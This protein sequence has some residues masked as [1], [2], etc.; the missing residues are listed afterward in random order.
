MNTLVSS[1]TFWSFVACVF[2]SISTAAHAGD[3]PQWRY[4]AARS[5]TSPDELPTKLHLQWTRQLPP[6]RPAWPQNQPALRFDVSYSPVAAGKMLFVPSMVTDT[7]TAYDTETGA[8]RWRFYT[9]G[10]VRFAPIVDKGRLYAASD[11]GYLYCLDAEKGTQ[12]W[13]FRA[14]PIERNVLGNERLISTWPVRGGPVLHDGTVYLTAG[15]WPFMG[16]FVYA[17]SAE[18]GQPTWTNSTLGSKYQ[19][20]PHGAPSFGGL[21]PRGHLAVTQAGLV[22]PGGRTSP[23]TFDLKTGQL[24]SFSFGDKGGGRTEHGPV[25]IRAGSRTFTPGADQITASDGWFADVQ[26]NVWT[27]LAADDKLF[28]VTTTG[29]VYCFGGKETAEPKKYNRDLPDAKIAG[30]GYCVFFGLG[31]GDE[32]ADMLANSRFYVIVIDPDANKID[33]FRRR[34]TEAGFYGVRVSAH[35]G[36]PA[37]DPVGHPLPPYL[38]KRV[39]VADRDAA[40]VDQGVPLVNAVFRALRPYGGEAVLP[41]ESKELEGLAKQAE[42]VGAKVEPRGQGQSLLV[43]EGPLPGAA[44]W[45][46]NYA[47]AGN[48][49]VSND[50]RAKAPLGL[51]WFGNGPP[52][53]A[54]LPRHGHGPSP[55]VAEGRLFI[56][57]ADMIRGIDIYT[58]ALLWQRSLPGLGQF[59]N[60]T[61]H[62]PGAGEI[63]SNYVSL[64]DSVYVVYGEKILRLDAATGTTIKEFTLPADA[65]GKAPTWGYV[66][67]WENLLIATSTPVK[68][69]PEPRNDVQ[70]ARGVTG[71]RKKPVKPE[72]EPRPVKPEPEPRNDVDLFT[73]TAY[74]SASK[75]LVVM[76][77][78]SGEV[79]WTRDA[80]YNFRHNNIAVAAGMVFCIDGLSQAKQDAL[81]RRGL[82]AESFKP[83]L[84]AL[85]T[86]SGKEIWSTGEDVFGTF[87]N[88]SLQHDVLLQSG[89]RS[90][91][92]ARDESP[93][94]MV[95]YRGKDGTVLWKNLPISV[96]GPCLLHR[97]SIILQGPALSLLTGE[98]KMQEHPLTGEPMPWRFTRNYGCNTAVASENLIT[99]RSG[100]AGYFDMANNGGTG[101]LGGFKSGCTSNLIVAGGLVNAPEYT[102]TCTCNY[103]N[104]TS[105]ALFHD[106]GVETWTF[107]SFDWDGKP[108]R[109]VGINLGAPGDRRG[110]NGTLWMDV[111]STGGASPNIPVDVQPGNVAFFRNHSLLTEADAENGEFAWVAAS[112][113]IGVTD[114][115]LALTKEA[116]NERLYT[117]RLHFA[118]V[119]NLRPG[120]RVF[121]ISLQ[122][123]ELLKDFDVVREAGGVRRAVMQEFKGV[124]AD[125]QLKI[126][127][128][129]RGDKPP[130]LC[131]IEVIAE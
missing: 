26:G 32:V 127:L 55:Q 84:M 107:N 52:N 62:Q 63:G 49:V 7:V 4:D 108:I 73:P 1:R 118:E 25:P 85:D 58:G 114:V 105:L 28:V 29:C 102:R 76:N 8:E 66:G 79:I 53:G 112:G 56:E 39:I 35:V 113:A 82:T 101:N 22:A 119:E 129:P 20:H 78:E 124:K 128:T 98:P 100:A 77:R 96:A 117:V 103:Q 92:R 75:Q 5:A 121:G 34:M 90:R 59:Y 87:L 97:D 3:W 74:S 94:G 111:P 67:A 10:P 36:N 88:Y 45:T 89:S 116:G 126:T 61:N 106:P 40:G 65:N 93:T 131:G 33:A 60:N 48:S 31:N 104:Q 86:R 57:G 51:L 37:G 71:R 12:L 17:V 18:T 95:A 83:R 27:V 54:V 6:P 2:V 9:G 72:P 110:D 15:V 19:T 130:I 80:K 70:A 125:H 24:L 115:T 13:R 122:G 120:Q 44:D 16:I 68:P 41:I 43:R 30:E 109:Q 64:A 23:G 38:A 11:D 50:K 21:V 81:Q 14:A 46:H 47:D 91:D 42:L 99:F 123:K 69:E